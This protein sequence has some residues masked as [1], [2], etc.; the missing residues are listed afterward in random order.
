MKR[1]FINWIA[2]AWLLF[3]FFVIAYA[4]TFPSVVTWFIV[5]AFTFML[6]T[7]LFTAWMK[8]S[9]EP[10]NWQIADNAHLSL[11]I[12]I[13]QRSKWLFLSPSFKLI[14]YSDQDKAFHQVIYP[15]LFFKNHSTVHLDALIL[16]R[17][18][19]DDLKVGIQA[20]GLFG[21]FR[22]RSVHKLPLDLNIY[23]M[24]LPH[25]S[26]LKLL[27]ENVI[28]LIG[29][30][31]LA[32]Q[33][34]QVKELRP[35]Q[36]RDALSSID[37]KSSMK[38]DQ[39]MIKDYDREEPLP[40]RLSFI[41]MPSPQFESLLSLAYSLALHLEA[42]TK[43]DLSLI[44]AFDGQSQKRKQLQDFLMIQPSTDQEDLMVL[45][46]HSENSKQ[47]TIIITSNRSSLP[48]SLTASSHTFILDER[49]LTLLKGGG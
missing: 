22:H 27:T 30:D 5:Y 4:L 38:R 18:H 26:V 11:S 20:T 43:L 6:L 39:W 10:I 12:R 33:A 3:Y 16:A 37:W 19:Y 36:S 8:P 44:G 2:C 17:G 40:V 35:Y 49:Q 7:A 29:S 24:R 31:P 45:L 34:Y 23:P 28:H 15:A 21:I 13:K 14:L 41:G 42:T 48:V 47:T 32:Q 1:S 25:A 9:I 46:G